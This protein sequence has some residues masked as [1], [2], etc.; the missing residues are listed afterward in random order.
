MSEIPVLEKC[1]F[2]LHLMIGFTDVLQRFSVVDAC[3]ELPG[4]TDHVTASS[5]ILTD[6]PVI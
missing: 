2:E 5:T 6:N 3:C 1:V 4:L